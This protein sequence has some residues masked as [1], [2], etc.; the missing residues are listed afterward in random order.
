MI[1]LILVSFCVTT[2]NCQL[3]FTWLNQHQFQCAQNIRNYREA[4]QHQ[5]MCICARTRTC[6]VDTNAHYYNSIHLDHFCGFI[7]L[8]NFTQCEITWSIYVVPNIHINFLN[9]SLFELTSYWQC[10]F[11][12][13]RAVTTNKN[14]TFCGRRLPWVYDASDSLVKLIFIT[15]RFG[16]Q[17]YQLQF[18]YYGAYITNNQ[19]FVLFMEPSGRSDMHMPNINQNEF[20][21]F[22]FISGH[23]LEVVYL[24]A[25]NVCSTQQVVCYDGPGMKSPA[26]HC[27][28]STYQSSTFQMVCKFS[29]PN[30]GCLTAPRL[31]FQVMKQT[32]GDFRRIR[33]IE[34][35]WGNLLIHMNEIA[36]STSKYIYSNSLTSICGWYPYNYTAVLEIKKVNISFP[37]MLHEQQSCM[38]GGVYIIDKSSSSDLYGD[39]VLSLC[40]TRTEFDINIPNW[41][42]SILI[43]HY[44]HYSGEQINF[45]AEIPVRSCR[46]KLVLR[47]NSMAANGH[48]MNINLTSAMFL[49]RSYVFVESYLLDLIEIQY[50]HIVFDVN[51][52]AVYEITF[53][54]HPPDN[55]ESCV[56][57]MVFFAKQSSNFEARHYDA[58]LFHKHFQLIE[59][60]EY[61]VINMSACDIF[62]FPVWSLRIYQY[63]F[64]NFRRTYNKTDFQILDPLSWNVFDYTDEFGL[65]GPIWF[66]IHVQPP[67]DVPHYAI[68]KV[69]VGVAAGMSHVY[70]EVLTDSHRSSS[71][72]EWDHHGHIS[73]SIFEWDKRNFTHVYMTV[74]TGINFFFNYTDRNE[75]PVGT[76]LTQLIFTRQPLYDERLA[77]SNKIPK[78]DTCTFYNTR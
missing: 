49:K 1:L 39:E 72:Y 20:E 58:D 34:R 62:T 31:I 33:R 54:V 53:S 75:I 68:W 45:E 35:K 63:R 74:D 15:E 73:R 7:S 40:D 60:F 76:I 56:Y 26:I 18:Q 64:G 61:V 69:C 51:P 66:I 52:L 43:I 55:S 3:T 67:E 71:V 25:V 57:C 50:A 4:I 27:N 48:R 19:H 14:S 23:R 59:R 44:E 13:L 42:F 47:Q 2:L 12:Y 32:I 65:T 29:R 16:V 28:Q 37:Y 9:F 36:N 38:Y 46:G 21:T 8:S 41:N 17:E 10:D 78:L 77:I 5:Y 24:A 30:S 11:E 6:A 22:H 70:M